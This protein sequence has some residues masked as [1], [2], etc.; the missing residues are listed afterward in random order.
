VGE[1]ACSFA[2]ADNEPVALAR[3]LQL[4]E[5]FLIAHPGMPSEPERWRESLEAIFEATVHLLDPEPEVDWLFAFGWKGLRVPQVR[6]RVRMITHRRALQM[7]GGGETQLLETLSALSEEGVV[8]D[9]S[10]AL[11]LPE[12]PYDLNH[13]FSLVPCRPT[14]AVGTMR[15]ALCDF[16]H[17]LG[18][19]RVVAGERGTPC[20]L[21]SRGGAGGAIVAG[22][23][24]SATHCTPTA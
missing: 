14:G 13:L 17:L 7:L 12:T 6:R 15:E 10:I 16:H 2:Y 18:L 11:R 21:F 4:G 22:R 20:H 24:A 9:V 19:L 8:A 5:R 23:L 1:P 3:R